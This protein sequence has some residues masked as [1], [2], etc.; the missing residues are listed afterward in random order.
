MKNS[1]DVS[2][3]GHI[4]I[5][6]LALGWGVAGAARADLVAFYNFESGAVTDETGTHADGVLTNGAVISDS[7][8]ATGAARF[9]NVLDTTAWAKDGAI[10]GN[11]N[12]VSASGDL[13]IACWLYNVASSPVETFF[14][15]K[16]DSWSSTNMMFQCGIL[17]TDQSPPGQVRWMRQGIAAV[18]STQAFP[19]NTW[20]HMA[21]TVSNNTTATLY[22]NGTNVGSSA[23]S[24]GT[25]TTSVL[26]L[27]VVPWAA[28]INVSYN[29]YMDDVAFYDEALS[30]DAVRALIAD[31]GLV[32]H[33]DFESGAVRDLTG[34]H[35][36]GVLTNGA[37]ITN[38]GD[39]RY[40]KVLDTTAW[41][42]DGAVLGTWNP[43]SASGNLSIACWLKNVGTSSYETTFVSG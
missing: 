2:F 38:S 11:W 9:G 33:Y 31:Q 16:T 36:D 4:L 10:L 1:K 7:G 39:D 26:T 41:A 40:G 3:L 8:T 30:E 32:A 12:P 35:A 17:A 13:T 34:I 29:G 14:V 15:Q 43:V 28:A 5:M 20:A 24:F 19:S 21:I 25:D 18:T 42:V 6:T 37:V 23:W 27:G 22:I